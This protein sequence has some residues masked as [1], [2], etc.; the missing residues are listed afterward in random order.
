[1]IQFIK[2][3]KMKNTQLEDPAVL[4]GVS[5]KI[6]DSE[7]L[8]FLQTK[9]I[10]WKYINTLKQLTDFNDDVI[11]DW[12]NISVRT[13]RTYRQPENK[14]KENIKEHILLLISLIKHGIHVFGTSKGLSEWLN[15]GNFY[16]D[17]K[18]PNDYLNTVSGIRFVDDRLTALEFG[19]NV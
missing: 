3:M 7:V 12:L 4:Y 8:A 19:D 11:S 13:L 14:F 6:S 2:I 17:G 10:N 15:T 5:G 9:D 16:F 18:N 1:M